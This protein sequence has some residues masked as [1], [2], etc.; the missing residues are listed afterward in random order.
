MNDQQIELTVD[1]KNLYREE[2]ISDLKV[3]SIRILKPVH[4]DGSVDSSREEIFVG[5]TQIMTPQGMI[6]LQ[7]KLNAKTLEKAIDEFPNAMQQAL[8]KMIE[9]VKRMQ[10]QESKSPKQDDSRIIMPG[11]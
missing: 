2:S 3:G 10:E 8:T 1:K 6:P 7:A 11:R 9:E 4:I 5:N